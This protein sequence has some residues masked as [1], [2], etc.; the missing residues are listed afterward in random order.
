MPV[1]G[2]NSEDAI[3]GGGGVEASFHFWCSI[4]HLEA[5][6]KAG[7]YLKW[8]WPASCRQQS[9]RMVAASKGKTQ[10]EIKLPALIEANQNLCRRRSD[11]PYRTLDPIIY[12]CAPVY[13]PPALNFTFE[14]TWPAWSPPV[15]HGVGQTLNDLRHEGDWGLRHLGAHLQ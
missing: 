1:Q 8:S 9:T 12:A 7:S 15:S 6:Q 10:E 13:R 2:C 11:C 4:F 3:P 5:M 14:K